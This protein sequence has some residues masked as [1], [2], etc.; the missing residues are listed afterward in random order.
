MGT[1]SGVIIDSA[2]Q[3]VYFTNTTF[4]RVGDFSLQTMTLS[5]PIQVG[6]LP[7][8]LDL[9]PDGTRLYVANSGGSNL[10]VVNLV[11]RVAQKIAIPLPAGAVET[12]YSFAIAG[13]G[14][15]LYSTGGPGRFGRLMQLDLASGQSTPRQDYPSSF[16]GSARLRA[17]DSRNT[18][19]TNDA[20]YFLS[21]SA[22]SNTFSSRKVTT[23]SNREVASDFAAS[24]FLV[25]GPSTQVFDSALNLMGS[26]PGLSSVGGAAV[27]SDGMIGYRATQSTVSV[28]NLRSYLITGQ[29]PLGDAVVSGSFSGGMDLSDDG[30]LLAVI[31]SRGI[32]LV[33]TNAGTQ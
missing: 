20:S 13:N 17:N 3:H 9:T 30:S 31:T 27:S 4:N 26:F 25:V 10:S 23:T 29:L 19:V 21:Y 14:L 11:T 32:S 2:C 12:P 18:I 6:S 28:L 7:I 5:A 8:G 1:V 24:V 22:T 33:R 15:A 16:A